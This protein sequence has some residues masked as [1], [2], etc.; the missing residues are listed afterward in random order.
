M[1]DFQAAPPPQSGLL[2]A[3]I[4]FR[5]VLEESYRH[6]ATWPGSVDPATGQFLYSLARL[7]RPDLA[8]EVGTYRG[9]STLWLARAL[10]DNATGRLLSLDLFEDMPIS[11]VQA[12]LDR[13]GLG[14][15]VQLVCGPSVTVG[16]KAVHQARGQIDL[17]FID[18]D[19]RVEATAA[20]FEVLGAMV[21]EGGFAVLHDIYPEKCSWDGPRFV[22]NSLA[23]NPGLAGNWQA[24]ELPTP[25]PSGYGLALLRK[26]SSERVRI[27]PRPAYWA[28]KWKYLLRQWFRVKRWKSKGHGIGSD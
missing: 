3:E 8:V 20:D 1:C 5:E 2:E 17:L 7:I 10:E 28:Y 4:R 23:E 6:P 13:A 22:L 24:I 26:I 15:R 14:G 12:V 27:L 16:A 9:V 11:E 18:G 21:R 19:H 25:S